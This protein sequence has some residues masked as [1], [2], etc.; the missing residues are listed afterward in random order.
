MRANFREDSNYTILLL[1]P[2][3]AGPLCGD[4]MNLT[5]IKTEDSVTHFQYNSDSVD[6]QG[7]EMSL[8]VTSFNMGFDGRTIV[9]YLNC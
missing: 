7:K 5:V 4:D 3:D 9:L 6:T 8:I 2:I 1:F